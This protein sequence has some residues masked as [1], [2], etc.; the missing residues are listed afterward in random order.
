M[1]GWTAKLIVVVLSLLI[2]VCFFLPFR[3]VAYDMTNTYSIPGYAMLLGFTFSADGNDI[4]IP[5]Q[6]FYILGFAGTLILF[7][8]SAWWIIRRDQVNGAFLAAIGG[9]LCLVGFIGQT[10][11]EPGAYASNFVLPKIVRALFSGARQPA[12][13][14]AHILSVFLGLSVLVGYLWLAPGG[15]RIWAI[16]TRRKLNSAM[17]VASL[18]SILFFL[19]P[20]KSIDLGKGEKMIISGLSLMTGKTLSSGGVSVVIP[21]QPMLLAFFALAC[22]TIVLGLIHVPQRFRWIMLAVPVLAGFSIFGQILVEM[23]IYSANDALPAFARQAIGGNYSINGFGAIAALLVGGVIGFLRIKTEYDLKKGKGLL[24]HTTLY[25]FMLPGI[26]LF[27]VFNYLPMF[28]VIMAFQRYDPVSGF[29]KSEWVGIKNFIEIFRLPSFILAFRNTLLIATIRLVV[30]FPMPIIFALLINELR[31]FKFKRTVQSISYL[32]NFISWVI[33]AGIWY[34]MLSPDTGIINQALVT[35]GVVDEPIF[36]MQNKGWFYPIIIFTSIWKNLGFSSILYMACIAAIDQEQYEAAVVDGAGRFRQMVYITWPG[37]RNTIVLLFILSVSGLLNA[38][39]DQLWTMGNAAVR[40]MSE[41]LD[42]LVLRYLTRGS[43][44]DL[45]LGAA[46]GMFKSVV[47][48]LLFFVANFVS[49]KFKQE[50]LI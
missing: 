2:L 36:F 21:P 40:D 22:L 18:V 3:T 5:P 32:P 50:S 13:M 4:Y 16:I 20:V 25:L 44:K 15:R 48:L 35:L 28:G 26:I 12:A 41:I 8:W 19:L 11:L 47:G 27:L 23:F 39:F 37:M 14:A 9:F 42:T 33:V 17:I 29:F 49:R 10:I 7:F 31:V 34:Q 1:K 38:G 43:F 6:I 45:S 24:D 30:E 46:M